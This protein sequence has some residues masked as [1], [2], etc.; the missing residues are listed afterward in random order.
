MKRLLTFILS[1]LVVAATFAQSPEAVFKSIEQYPNLAIT[2]GSTYPGIPFGEVEKAPKG[3]KPFYFTMVGRHGSRYEIVQHLTCFDTFEILDKANKLGILTADG[4]ALHKQIGDICNVQ[5]KNHGELSALGFK[6]WEGI[7]TRTYDRFGKIF[8]SGKIEAKSSI[9]MRCVLSMVTFNQTLKGL[10]PKMDI[11]Q[12]SRK[13]ELWILRPFA[14]NPKVSKKMKAL[15][16]DIYKNGEWKKERDEF[17]HSRDAS[18]FISKITT[19]RDA[20]INECGAKSDMNI[21]YLASYTLLFAENFDMGDRELLTRLFTTKDLY[22]VYVYCTAMWI[23]TMFGRGN[24]Y[25][26][27][28]Q[29]SVRSL[30]EDILNKAQTAV[31]GK[32]PHVANLRFTHDSYVGPLLSVI[33][34]DGCVPKW[35]KDIEKATTSFNHGTMSPM[36]ANLQIALYRN[37]KGEVLIRSLINERDAYLPIECETA[38]FYPWSEFCKHVNKNLDYFDGVHDRVLKQHNK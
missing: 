5:K 20:L 10:Y 11:S 33:G 35:D 3:F 14:N 27:M 2:I 16:N 13:S 22:N 17:L 38:P 28:R 9:S 37:K 32:N 36:A 23:N 34:Y 24:E 4:K 21:A 7:A 6:Q 19:N 8:R 15:W 12:N 18:S 26:E 29:A 31:D 25:A 1:L 30:A